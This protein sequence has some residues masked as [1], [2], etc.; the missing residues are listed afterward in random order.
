MSF[1]KYERDRESDEY[2][3]DWTINE[4]G[5]PTM[6]EIYNNSKKNIKNI[7]EKSDPYIDPENKKTIYEDYFGK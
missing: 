4:N 7:L 1:W 5:T 6:D 3:T 2:S